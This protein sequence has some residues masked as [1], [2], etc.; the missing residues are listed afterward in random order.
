M[1]DRTFKIYSLL[2][3]KNEADIIAASLTDACRWSDKIIV[4]DNGSTDGSWEQVQQL[5]SRYPQIVPF[6]QYT[7]HF[8]IGLRAKAFYAFRHE[9]KCG[10][11]WC[12]RLD[13]DEFYPTDVRTFLAH[14]PKRYRTI[15][16]ESTDY[17]LT[18][19]DVDNHVFS[20]DFSQDRPLLT[21]VLP[22]KRRERRFVRHSP[23]LIWKQTWRYPHLLGFTSPYPVPVDHFQYRSPEQMQRRFL[24]R[25]QAK[26]DGCGSFKHEQGV[27]WQDY[28]MT[29]AQLHER[30]LLAHIEEAFD[31]STQVLHSGR[32]TVKVVGGNL[33]VK[34]FK[35]PDFPNSLIYA[36]LRKSKAKRS[37]EY[38]LRLE[39]MTPE[40]VMYKEIR[41]HGLLR[42][43][44]Y[45]SRLSTLPYSFRQLSHTADFPDRE[46]HLKAVARF[47]AQ[48]H[49][50]GILHNDYSGGNILF[51]D[52]DNIQL[53]DLNRM[54]F[55]QHIGL[56]RGCRNFNRLTLTQADC[57]VMAA[58]YAEERHF[59]KERCIRIFLDSRNYI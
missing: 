12:V 48:L 10:D 30:Q 40:P 44:Y 2:L 8:H 7:G 36:T 34:R 54:T 25:R 53:V 4:I 37:Y 43:S 57:F 20:G 32:N 21:H 55:N 29:E 19:E 38:A 52:N 6:M 24:T 49:G 11:W 35:T 18:K 5:A 13:A 22:E 26:A 58:A 31:A 56:R 1:S 9:M 28:L 3:V 50:L 41:R 42:E 45:V 17:V 59:N 14:V 23:F 39:N 15:K 46:R 27:I 47:T 51:D 33:V 16:K